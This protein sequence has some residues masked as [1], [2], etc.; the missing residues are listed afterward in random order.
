MVEMPCFQKLLPIKTLKIAP[1]NLASK[2]AIAVYFVF[3]EALVFEKCY[4][5]KE[6]FLFALSLPL[7]NFRLAN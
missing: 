7:A 1:K 3:N 6:I 5:F 4:I 2:S